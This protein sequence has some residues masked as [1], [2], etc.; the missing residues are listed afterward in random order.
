MS[1]VPIDGDQVRFRSTGKLCS[2]IRKWRGVRSRSRAL[3]LPTRPR[4]GLLYRDL[5]AGVGR[6]GGGRGQGSCR[7]GAAALLTFQA[8]APSTTHHAPRTTPLHAARGRHLKLQYPCGLAGWRCQA[9]R[10]RAGNSHPT[11]EVQGLCTGALQASETT[12]CAKE[13]VRPY[14]IT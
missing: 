7:A 9:Q 10:L 2:L 11:C 4:A 13:Q 3:A 1:F 14:L 8:A 6:R 12:P 5:A